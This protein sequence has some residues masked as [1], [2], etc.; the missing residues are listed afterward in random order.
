MSTVASR[1]QA[2][3]SWL[4]RSARRR[5]TPHRTAVGEAPR[6]VAVMGR[7]PG[8]EA[9]QAVF[10]DAGWTLVFARSVGSAIAYLEK[11][12]IPIVLYEREQQ[13]IEWREA[14]SVF[15]PQS[16]RGGKWACPG[17]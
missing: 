9:L 14:V 1:I 7:G 4:R 5:S 13:E 2:V 16:P 8:R 11:K 15:S 12:P 6:A 3:I 17:F 10:R